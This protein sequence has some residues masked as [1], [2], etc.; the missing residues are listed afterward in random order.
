MECG[1]RHGDALI[2]TKRTAALELLRWAVVECSCARGRA[3]LEVQL[4]LT[5]SCVDPIQA[6]L[7]SSPPSR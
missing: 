6:S 4:Q 5:C 1:G 3:R 7:T 2:A